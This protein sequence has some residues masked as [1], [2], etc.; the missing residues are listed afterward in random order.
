MSATS[1]VA[2]TGG[3]TAGFSSRTAEVVT[4]RAGTART[5]PVATRPAHGAADRVDSTAAVVRRI[6]QRGAR[7]GP[8]T[9]SP[10]GTASA[11]RGAAVP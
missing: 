9:P 5:S 2:T 3:I 8:C 4:D 10:L 1:S 7:A 11:A 6:D